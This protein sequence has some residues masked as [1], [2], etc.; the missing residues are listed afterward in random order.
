[1][2]T[3]IAQKN[4]EAGK[5]KP[6]IEDINKKIAGLEKD[7]EDVKGQLKQIQNSIADSKRIIKENEEHLLGQENLPELENKYQLLQKQQE[8]LSLKKRDFEKRFFAFVRDM[9]VC[10]TFYPAAKETLEIIDEKRAN[11]ALPPDIDK[12]V[13]Q[14][15]LITH[16]CSIC[17]H[18]LTESETQNIR[19]MLERIQVSSQTSNLLMLIRN[20][21][22][23]IVSKAERYLNDKTI[24]L[25]ENTELEQ[26]ISA[27]EQELQELDDQI[28]KFSNKQQVIQWHEERNKHK[29]LLDV[30]LPKLGALQIQ[31]KQ[32]ND[33]IKTEEEK[34]TKEFAKE[35][36]L[37]QLRDEKDF[38]ST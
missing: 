9:K 11:N 23:H 4:S 35:T 19:E 3:I 10:L 8:N 33:L 1:M 30:N 20:E 27:C 38:L 31:E 2:Q 29:G 34:R 18:G 24:L 7:L 14:K 16:K 13:L 28:R 5:K 15:I 36:Q 26:R 37:K 25:N 32:L 12:E 6:Q 17:G 21:L 22:E